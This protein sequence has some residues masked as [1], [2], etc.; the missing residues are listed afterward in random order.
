MTS[1]NSLFIQL[2]ICVLFMS[3]VWPQRPWD[4]ARSRE[5]EADQCVN[6]HTR[7]PCK[8]TAATLPPLMSPWKIAN[9][10]RQDSD[11]CRKAENSEFC[12][13]SPN[14]TRLAIKFLWNIKALWVTLKLATGC[15]LPPGVTTIRLQR[16]PSLPD[17]PIFKL[18]AYRYEVAILLDQKWSHFQ[19]FNI[20]YVH[21]QDTGPNWLTTCGPCCHPPYPTISH[22]EKSI[23]AIFLSFGT[24]YVKGT[25]Q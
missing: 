10:A 7:E 3:C 5:P 6:G 18:L 11:L 4:Q 9:L 17:G 1:S 16:H 23:R 25:A 2:T 8:G 15:I 12:L 24:S 14:K 21:T 20:I 22:Q 13:K 19:W